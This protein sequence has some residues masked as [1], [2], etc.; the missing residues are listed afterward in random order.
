MTTVLSSQVSRS[1]ELRAW[2]VGLRDLRHE[3]ID[4][5]VRGRTGLAG[6]RAG[7]RCFATQTGA[8]RWLLGLLD[9][10]GPG[11][12]AAEVA[13][14]VVGFL[15]RRSARR[16]PAAVLADADEFVRAEGRGRLVAATLVDVDVPRHAVRI[17]VAGGVVPL[18]A[19][20]SGDVVALGDRGPALGLGAGARWTVAG[21]VPLAPGHVLPAT[22]DGVPDRAR[23]DGT[24]FGAR[25]VAET[26]RDLR[27]APPRAVVRAVLDEAD[28]WSA[29]DRSDRSALALRL[30]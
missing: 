13:R 22:T 7:D 16:E 4:L 6:V 28:R 30:R 11:D 25:R 2:V 19:G 9:A 8:G 5:A 27:S 21:P 23:A 12:D 24:T 20:R 29:D 10:R 26:L 18:V 17:A 14:E 3:G 1:T 15:R